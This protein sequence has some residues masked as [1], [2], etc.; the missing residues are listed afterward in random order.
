[1]TW[2]EARQEAERKLTFI[3]ARAG[4][5]YG[6]DGYGDGYLDVLTEEILALSACSDYLME[7]CKRKMEVRG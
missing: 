3:N 6:E 5:K 1:M 7:D 4:R 2:E